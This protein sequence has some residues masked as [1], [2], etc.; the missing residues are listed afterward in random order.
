MKDLWLILPLLI[1]LLS[2]LLC[3][4]LRRSPF[5]EKLAVASALA[6]L[7]VAVY[8]IAY[9][10]KEGIQSTALG[11]WPGP[12]GIVLVLDTFAA[13][14]VFTAA[15]V[16]LAVTLYSLRGIDPGR[17]A[18]GYFAFLQIMLFGVQG[19]F[20]TGDV[21][22]LYVWL[23]VML[24]S[25]F[26]LL[27]LGGERVQL[28]GGLKYFALNFLSSLFY[29]MAVG[30]LY[31][32]TG[33]LNL[34]DL[35][36][37][38]A[39]VDPAQVSLVAGFFL[40]A[41]SIKAALFPLFFWLPASYHTPP[42]P[43][44]AFFAALPTKVAVYA[45]F[46]LFTVLFH[47]EPELWHRLILWIAG[48]TMVT[49]VLG[50]LAQMEVRRLLSF[51][52]ISQ[53]GY[54][55]MGLGLFTPVGI[56]GGIFYIVHHIFVKAALFLVAGL[57][58][59]LLGSFHLE[60]LGGLYRY[61]PF[62]ALLFIIPALSLAGL[63]PFSGFFAK[64]F[65]VVGG[66]EIGEY[67]IVGVAL[68]VG[69]FTLMSMMKIWREAFWKPLPEERVRLLEGPVPLTMVLGTAL[70]SFVTVFIGLGAGYGFALAEQAA[71]ELL[72]PSAYVAAVLGGAR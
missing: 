18:L 64:L 13:L 44:A 1:P 72:D 47:Q 9:V 38:L 37:R 56:A 24:L 66:L 4:F 61:R 32:L 29:L 12:F 54:M 42:L 26:V 27:T 60:E 59:R 3:F 21:F 58:Q 71:R 45:L 15:L 67:A 30:L 70:L 43:V 34:A 7:G 65:L 22:N 36:L 28:L 49:G 55:V 68:L 40:L 48:F 51:H 5:G 19:A 69:L 31:G 63:P 11:N 41:L 20:L 62:F 57:A 25:S 23:E 52:I 6:Q 2:G 50:A 33:S 46:R 8:L 14:M 17:K 53:I 16:G 35:H 10:Q 39:H